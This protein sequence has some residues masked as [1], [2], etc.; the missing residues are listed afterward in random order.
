MILD[1]GD[2]TTEDI[3]NGEDTSAARRIPES[4]WTAACRKLDLLN[5]AHDLRDLRVP[6]G[7]RLEKLK[8]NLAAFYSIRI[9]SQYRLIFRWAD[10]TAKQVRITDYHS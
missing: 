7:N 1:F 5:A 3:F 10:G 6:P 4:T 9:N 8:G 2:R